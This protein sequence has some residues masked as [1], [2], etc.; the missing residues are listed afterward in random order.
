VIT[1]SV[2]LDK[3][4]RNQS[5]VYAFDGDTAI[6]IIPRNNMTINGP[7]IWKNIIWNLMSDSFSFLK[8]YSRRENSE[9]GFSTDKRC[10]GWRV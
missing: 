3:Y 9:S 8:E 2:K 6:Y 1:G 4:Y 7:Y 10:D 5:T